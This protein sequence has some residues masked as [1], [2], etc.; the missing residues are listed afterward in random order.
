[1]QRYDNSIEYAQLAMQSSQAKDEDKKQ[2]QLFI[3][4]VENLKASG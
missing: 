2:L 4:E 3:N 1:M